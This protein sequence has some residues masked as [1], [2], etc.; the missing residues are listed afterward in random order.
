MKHFIHKIWQISSLVLRIKVKVKQINH[1]YSPV[2]YTY[3]LK[4]FESTKDYNIQSVAT[5]QCRWSCKP[6]PPRTHRLSR[7][8]SQVL[9]T[10][11]LVKKWSRSFFILKLYKPLQ[12]YLLTCQANSAILGRLFALGSSKIKNLDHF[13]SSF[14]SQMCWF[15][16]LRFYSIY[17]TSSRWCDLLHTFRRTMS[18]MYFRITLSE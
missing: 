13:S 10:A 18:N 2:P 4:N 16:D 3:K 6:T 15:Q 9:K 14:L 1:L 12:R 11:F 17:S 8:K 7:L 5:S